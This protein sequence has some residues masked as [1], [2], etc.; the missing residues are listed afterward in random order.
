MS[1]EV[2]IPTSLDFNGTRMFDIVKEGWAKLGVKATLKVGGDATASYA[3]ETDTK[4]DASKNVGYSK[5]DIA[6]WDWIAYP[7]P[8][9]QLSVVTKGQWCSWSDTGWDNPAY[10]RLYVKQG[11]TVNPAQRRAIVYKMQKMV[12]DSFVY[13]QL[14]NHVALDATSTKWTGFKNQLNAYAKLY[15]TSPKKAS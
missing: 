2:I 14:T 3:L 15:Y 10:D 13:T 1:Y 11:V 4:C 6:M 12:Y 7:D 9:F 8:D 5:F